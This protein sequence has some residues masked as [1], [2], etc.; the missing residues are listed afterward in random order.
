MRQVN[1]ERTEETFF[2]ELSGYFPFVRE[3]D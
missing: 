3:Y 2:S 1:K